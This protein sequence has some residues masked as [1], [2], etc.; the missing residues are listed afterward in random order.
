MTRA[1]FDN[2]LHRVPD[3]AYQM[4]YVIGRRLT[5]AENT[6]IRDLRSKGGKQFHLAQGTLRAKVARQPPAEPMRIR[7]PDGEATVLGTTLKLLVEVVRALHEFQQHKDA[8]A[9]QR[10]KDGISAFYDNHIKSLMYRDWSGFDLF[11]LE[12]PK[13]GVLQALQQVAPPTATF[14]VPQLR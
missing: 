2:L 6:T 3:L 4:M 5:E 14:R 11:Y 8:A 12:I 9:A 7:V 1:E 13:G 10:M